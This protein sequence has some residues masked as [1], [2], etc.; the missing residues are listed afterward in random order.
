MSKAN[1]RAFQ[2]KANVRLR[3]VWERR[4]ARSRKAKTMNEGEA[5]A[6]GNL[7]YQPYPREAVIELAK[8]ARE[9][10]VQFKINGCPFGADYDE[11]LWTRFHHTLAERAA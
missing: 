7:E 4:H 10:G 8:K 5:Y 2:D 9:L 11:K 3:K 1:R 6:E